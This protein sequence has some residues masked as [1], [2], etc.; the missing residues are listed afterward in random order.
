MNEI[1]KNIASLLKKRR[2]EANKT[3]AEFSEAFDI[4][5]STLKGLMRGEKALRTDTVEMISEKFDVP[6]GELVSGEPVGQ[7]MTIR[8]ALSFLQS[9]VHSIPEPFRTAAKAMLHSLEEVFRLSDLVNSDDRTVFLPYQNQND[10]YRYFVQESVIRPRYGLVAKKKMEVWITVA[11]VPGISDNYYSVLG[12][13]RDCTKIQLPPEQL[14]DV[15]SD[16]LSQTDF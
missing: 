11:L 4:P 7:Q 9:R 12:L 2:Q 10:V 1:P 3:M 16:F 5:P 14:I 15:V 13:A 6:L 8:T